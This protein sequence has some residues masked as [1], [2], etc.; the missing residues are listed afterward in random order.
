MDESNLSDNMEVRRLYSYDLTMNK[1]YSAIKNKDFSK[2]DENKDFIALV[3]SLQKEGLTGRILSK[4]EFSSFFK[5]LFNLTFDVL[6]Q[7]KELES[8]DRF[9]LEFSIVLMAAIMMYDI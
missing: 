5:M 2:I 3:E 8:E 4:F 1:N 7:K 6:T 9:I